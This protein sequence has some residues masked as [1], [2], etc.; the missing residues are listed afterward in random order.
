[1]RQAI[2]YL[3]IILSL[4]GN[5]LF[6]IDLGFFQLTMFR[7][8]ILFL[9][10]ITVIDWSR[11]KKFLKIYKGN[12]FSIAFMFIWTLYSFLTF[13]WIKDYYS[14][15]RAV[16]FIGTGFLL[17]IIFTSYLDNKRKILRTFQSMSLMIMFHN[18]FGWYE[19]ITGNY[20]LISSIGKISR[21]SF[22]NN[23]VTIF[24]N[25]NDYA[26]FMLF[27]IFILYIC[28]EN[29]KH[30]AMKLLYSCFMISSACLL[31]LTDSRANI[32]AL[33][34]ATISFLFFWPNKQKKKYIILIM[35]IGLIAVLL[36]LNYLNAI[37]LEIGEGIDKVISLNDGSSYARVNLIKNG[38]VFLKS[39][40]GFGTG[41]G[42]IEY[43]MDNYGVYYT[44]GLTNVH[45]WWIE[46]L[47][48][49]GIVIFIMYMVFYIKLFL[50]FYK[51]LKNPED[52]LGM[53]LSLG[54]MCIMA[55]YT[56][57]SVSS[58]SNIKHDWLWIFWA[59]I[60]AYQGIREKGSLTISN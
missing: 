59:I 58:S 9:L 26:T 53:S 17:C 44:S 14:W 18:I 21:Y 56:V 25:T 10:F 2:I 29:T 4:T 13:I 24:G 36:N 30:W 20:L 19:I 43:W 42:N 15:A 46:I 54:I 40:Y 52:K 23:P 39:T 60:I 33:I 7:V 12:F 32:L 11:R 31:F 55:G 3:T 16:F 45:N 8:A 27:S 51:K 38:V 28:L 5:L 41:A 47:T 22:N 49:Y 34:I 35:P 48:G 1:M 6:S 57:G 37:F 50:S